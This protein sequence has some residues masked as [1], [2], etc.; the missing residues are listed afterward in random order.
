[1]PTA[2]SELRGV[3]PGAAGAVV[4]RDSR[5]QWRGMYRDGAG[6]IHD[7]VLSSDGDGQRS[8]EL[9]ANYLGILASEIHLFAPTGRMY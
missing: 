6:S 5:G 7:V 2:L 9:L 4:F 3:C 8:R 1:M